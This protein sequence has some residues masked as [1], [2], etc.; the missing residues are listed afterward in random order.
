[1]D[2]NLEFFHF[3]LR[4][5]HTFSS[6]I[7]IGL[8]YY[9]NFVQGGFMNE[10]E[11]PVKTVAQAKLFP[12]VMWWFRYGALWTFIFGLLLLTFRMHQWGISGT[13]YWVN[14]LSGSLM[15]TLMAYNVWFVIWPNQKVIISSAE[16]VAKGQPAIAGVA[17]RAARGMVASRTN[18]LFSIPMLF[19]MSGASHWQYAVNPA[20]V[21]PYFIALILVCGGIEFNAL[22]GKVGPL[23][24]VKGVL[25]YGFGFLAILFLVIS[26][27]VRG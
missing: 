2:M 4:W 21:W 6:I 9:I 11:A 5:L 24:T 1:M 25:N 12:K 23:A 18:V 20:M 19:F 7:W 3:L 14:I 17:D 22:K 16:G 8:L 13:S 15:A 27:L 10:I 26:F